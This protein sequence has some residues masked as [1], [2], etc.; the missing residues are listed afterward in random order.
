[1]PADSGAAFV[2]IQQSDAMQ[3]NLSPQQLQDVTSMKIVHV[4][5]LMEVQPDCIYIVAQSNKNV[6]ISKGFLCLFDA[7]PGHA[8]NSL[9]DFFFY[10]LAEEYRESAVGVIFSGSGANG[11]QGLRAIRKKGG[12]ALTQ[13]SM[14]NESDGM[15]DCAIE[16]STVDTLVA[17]DVLPDIVTSYLKSKSQG[18]HLTGAMSEVVQLLSRRM[19]NDFSQ[20]KRSTLYRRVDRR[21]QQNQISKVEDYVHFLNENPIELDLLFKELLIN[22]THFFRDPVMWQYVKAEIIPPILAAHPEGKTVRIWVPACSTGEEAYGFAILFREALEQRGV[23]DR[24]LVKIF[25][26]DLDQ[27][28]ITKARQGFYP[29]TISQYISLERLNRFFVKHENGYRVCNEIR[30]MVIFAPQNLI[31]DVPFSKLDILSCRNLLIYLDREL[32]KRL[33][34]LFYYAL[35]P[36]GILLLGTAESI[37]YFPEMFTPLERSLAVYKRLDNGLPQKRRN[38]IQGFS[39]QAMTKKNPSIS[40][41]EILQLSNIEQTVD[42]SEKNDDIVL[43]MMTELQLMREEMQATHEEMQ[44]SQEELRSS[45]EE[46]QSTNEELLSTNKELQAANAALVA[47]KSKLKLLYKELQTTNAELTTYLEAI[48][49]LALVSVSDRSGRIIEANDRFCETSGYGCSELIGQ[50]HRILNSGVHSSDFF[51]DMWETITNGKIWHKEI[52]NRRKSGS[53]YWVDSTIVP[54]KDSNGRI[55]RYISVRVDITARKQKELILHERL[56]ERTCLYAIRRE[57][58]QDLS[59]G[60]LCERIFDHLIPAMQFPDHAAC[61]ISIYEQRYTSSH[62]NEDLT[63]GIFARIKVDGHFCGQLQVFYREEKSF[64]LPDEQNLINYIADDFRLWLER[65]QLEQHISFMANHDVLTGLPNRLLLQD[66]L[67]QALAHNQR[68]HDFSAV[69]FIDLDHFKVVNDTLGHGFGDLLLKE[70]AVRLLSSI[71]SEDTA[72][73]Q[74]GDEFIVI[75]TEITDLEDVESIAKKILHLLALPYHINERILHIDSSIGIALYPKDGKD[76]DALLK[77]SDL[78]MYHAKAT[79]RSNYQFYSAEMDRL[80]QEKHELGNDLHRAI[81]NNELILYY[82]PIID[83]DTNHLVSLEVLLRWQHPEKGLIPPVQFIKLAEETGLILPIGDWVIRSVCEQLKAWQDQG[84]NVPRIAINLSVKQFQKKLFV[85]DVANI[86]TQ[87]KVSASCLT[88]EI[89]ESMLADNIVEVNE[90]LQQLSAMGFK[91]SIDDFGTGYSNL[92]YLKHYTIDALKIDRS[93]VRDI[94]IDENDA[95]I[96]TAIIA[97]AGSLNIQVIAEGVESKEQIDFLKQR[98]CSQYQ[99]FYFSKPLSVLETIRELKRF[100]N[101]CVN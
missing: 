45:N 82:Q 32:Q 51:I 90:T 31:A 18:F 68:H 54:F 69:L 93:F 7:E 74:G 34:P 85:Q 92:S 53:L 87:A 40:L 95:A 24:Y 35:N 58:E 99:G 5:N 47:S 37:D 10:S 80:I 16:A 91:I 21:M 84:L 77:H 29:I 9:I 50:D 79:G 38:L 75:L 88:L 65:R 15:R 67:S 56:K 41:E 83:M 2:V 98:G 94:A 64:M 27:D 49:Q 36:G 100:N 76:V 89:T 52:C 8:S 63:H 62:Y 11:T 70:V 71:R 86:L 81:R 30:Q 72:S 96:V 20:Y 66:R 46:L 59:V 3:E 28:A 14:F 25:A 6:F 60:E 97:M 12:L 33:F 57:M 1:M 55:I 26:T 73:R 48:G 17:P 19:G 4:E 61:M 101:P 43:A 44:T 23:Q 22:V 39:L 13:D 78:A 42:L